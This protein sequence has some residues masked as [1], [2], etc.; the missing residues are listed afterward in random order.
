MVRERVMPP[1]AVVRR[2]FVVFLLL[3]VTALSVGAVE[4]IN[5]KSSDL[6]PAMGRCAITSQRSSYSRSCSPITGAA[7]RRCRSM[8]PCGRK[9]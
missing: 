3:I 1:G 7:A 2:Y 9:P 5:L 6:G 8:L 4:R